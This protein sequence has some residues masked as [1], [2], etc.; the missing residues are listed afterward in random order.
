MKSL[1][2]ILFPKNEKSFNLRQLFEKTEEIIRSKIKRIGEYAEKASEYVINIENEV[3]HGVESLEKDIKGY[4]ETAKYVIPSVL[5]SSTT[6]GRLGYIGSTLLICGTSKGGIGG[7]WYSKIPPIVSSLLSIVSLIIGLY[8]FHQYHELSQELQD[9]KNNNNV[10]LI[11]IREQLQNINATLAELK[12][13][14]NDMNTNYNTTITNIQRQLEEINATIIGLE[15]NYQTSQEQ[16]QNLINQVQT[17]EQQLQALENYY[18]LEGILFGNN[19]NS[20]GISVIQINSVQIENETAYVQGTV[21]SSGA[22]V[23]LE[24]PVDYVEKVNVNIQEFVNDVQRNGWNPYLIIDRVDLQYM[25]LLNNQNGTYV[26]SIQ[27]NEPVKIGIA[28]T[29]ADPSAIYNVLNNKNNYY[30]VIQDSYPV[31]NSPLALWGY[32][33]GNSVVVDFSNNYQYNLAENM[34][35]IA[36]Q[37]INSPGNQNP[38]SKGIIYTYSI[39]NGSVSTYQNYPEYIVGQ[40]YIPLIVLEPEEGESII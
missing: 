21:S 29:P 7:N 33:S 30:I 1:E 35:S 5:A 22:N 31:Y 28:A 20:Y 25:T 8:D 3:K 13:N 4:L 24:I 37:I 32:K 2:K 39:F 19:N 26:I 40:T 16:I 6:L 27:P 23:I 18:T 14:L 10:S 15:N 34:I 12:N 36:D 11:A 17:L 9:I 38:T